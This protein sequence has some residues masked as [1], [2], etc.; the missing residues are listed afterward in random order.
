MTQLLSETTLDVCIHAA[1]QALRHAD[2]VS[3]TATAEAV[4]FVRTATLVGFNTP[5]FPCSGARAAG[6]AS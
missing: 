5:S 6:H 1:R 3:V 4:V 2:V